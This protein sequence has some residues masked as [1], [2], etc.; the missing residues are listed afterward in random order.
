MCAA[1][2]LC[3]LFSVI[4]VAALFLCSLFHPP[5]FR[6]KSERIDAT[7]SLL[8]WYLLIYL[9]IFFFS[10]FLSLSAI[11]IFC[12]DVSSCCSCSF[13]CCNT[14]AEVSP[15]AS[16]SQQHCKT[17]SSRCFGLNPSL[18]FLSLSICLTEHA[19][20]L[21]AVVQYVITP[22]VQFMSHIHV[23]SLGNKGHYHF[24]S[25]R[26]I[27]HRCFRGG[28]PRLFLHS[29][30]KSAVFLYLLISSL[31]S[32]EQQKN[33]KGSKSVWEQRTS[34]IRRQNLMTSR[35]AL[36]NE[37]DAED[38]WKVRYKAKILNVVFLVC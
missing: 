10:L 21:S 29:V 3:Q 28:K 17:Q 16:F 14:E 4:V 32:K 1:C 9:L 2:S 7:D 20:M 11:L 12:V 30:L 37:L 38:H 27:A 18:P 5:F 31:C 36:Y 26:V 6:V 24:F 23:L 19:S 8:D 13:L 22:F 35:E 33:S 34:E 25:P 15:A